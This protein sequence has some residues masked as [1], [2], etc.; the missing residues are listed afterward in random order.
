MLEFNIVELIPRFWEG[1]E[2]H[3]FEKVGSGEGKD[4]IVGV[5]KIEVWVSGSVGSPDKV[6]GRW[7]IVIEKRV[8][9]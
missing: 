4:N 3:F 2:R 6:E 1:I 8:H 5:P 9:K 7:A